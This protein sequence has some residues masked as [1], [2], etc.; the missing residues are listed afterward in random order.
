MKEKKFLSILC[1]TQKK[2]DCFIERKLIEEK[3]FNLVP[4]YAN[5]LGVILSSEK[6]LKMNEIAKKV[7]KDKSTITALTKKLVKQGYIKKEK[8]SRDKRVIYIVPTEL[9]LSMKKNIQS[10][11]NALY[12]QAY[13]NFTDNEKETFMDLLLRL[14]ENL[15][16]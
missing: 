15:I 5:I 14:N 12:N 6:P 1:D 3:V 7:G 9:T 11:Y 2:M 16:T 4:S 13:D 10:V 8:S